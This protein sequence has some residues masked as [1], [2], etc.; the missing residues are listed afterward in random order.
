MIIQSIALLDQFDK[1]INTFAMR[2]R[3]W[4]GWHFP[5]LKNIIKDNFMYAKCCAYIQDKSKLT[6]E[7]IPGLTEIVEDESLAQQ[8]FKAA[9][10]SMGMETSEQDMSN[11]VIFT[12]RMISLALYRKQLYTYLEDKMQTVAPNFVIPCWG[13]DFG[14][15]GRAGGG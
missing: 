15:G 14:G 9:K 7:R 13:G 3:E 2:V 10:I 1:D 11:I 12:E 5:E 4:Y 8:V 6:E